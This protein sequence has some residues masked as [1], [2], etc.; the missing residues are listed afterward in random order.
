MR[1][2]EIIAEI[3]EA[4]KELEKEPKKRRFGFFMRNKKLAE[5]KEWETYDESQREV[6]SNGSGNHVDE[7]ESNVLFD[8]EAI[9]AELASE[10]IQVKE[11]ESTLPPMKLNISL[12][13][14]CEERGSDTPSSNLRMTKSFD[15]ELTRTRA[16]ATLS[17]PSLAYHG[18]A[19]PGRLRRAETGRNGSPGAEEMPRSSE[20][21]AE[22]TIYTPQPSPHVKAVVRPSLTPSMS[23]PMGVQSLEHNAWLDDEAEFGKEQEITLSFE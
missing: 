11:I 17:S 19:S 4:R 16:D 7:P 9:R 12:A 18:S 20:G 15:G 1:Q 21:T 14:G 13:N 3:D 22:R 10:Q 6:H 8:I 2:R 5:K 23:M